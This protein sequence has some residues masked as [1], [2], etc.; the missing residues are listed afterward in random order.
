MFTQWYENG[1]KRGEANFVHGKKDGVEYAW[2][3][4]GCIK[5]ATIYKD[6]QVVAQ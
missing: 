4:D 6:G 3:K 2:A 1:Q 5:S